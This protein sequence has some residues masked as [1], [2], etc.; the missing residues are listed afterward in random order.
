MQSLHESLLNLLDYNS[1]WVKITEILTHPKYSSIYQ[2]N[3]EEEQWETLFDIALLKLAERIGEHEFLPIASIR[4]KI[5][6]I[7][8]IELLNFATFGYLIHYN[9]L[10]TESIYGD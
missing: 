1:G 7:V 10:S 4:S 2:H 5:P 6:D 8:R 9:L 3:P